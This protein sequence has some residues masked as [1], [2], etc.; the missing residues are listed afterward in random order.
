[1]TIVSRNLHL[2]LLELVTA[3]CMRVHVSDTSDQLSSL[4]GS[5]MRSI[6]PLAGKSGVSDVTD[7]FLGVFEWLA[8]LCVC[9]RMFNASDWLYSLSRSPLALLTFLQVYL[10]CSQCD[11]RVYVPSAC[12][13]EPQVHPFRLCAALHS[14]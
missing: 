7:T 8:T 11:G 5:P 3:L 6:A 9:A 10:N 2:G 1:M 12:L 14:Q 13:H 4:F